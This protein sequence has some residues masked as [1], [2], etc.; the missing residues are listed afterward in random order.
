MMPSIP[1][2]LIVLAIAIIIF[3]GKKITSLLSDMGQG[4]V[5]FKKAM[6]EAEELDQLAD[7]TTR[8]LNE[9]RTVSSNKTS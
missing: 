9:S 8:D 4:V 6:K 1:Q 5:G 7:H 3:G 2:L